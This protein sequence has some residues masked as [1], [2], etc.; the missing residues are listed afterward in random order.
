M[1][2]THEA[3]A[4]RQRR[5]DHFLKLEPLETPGS[6][7]DVD[8]RIDGADLVEVNLLGSRA[9]DFRLGLGQ[10]AEN[11]HRAVLDAGGKRRSARDDLT[12][13]AQVALGLRRA[14]LNVELQR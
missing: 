13:V 12:D 5:N 7:H 6:G 14:H 3:A 4:R 1:L 10:H 9:M 8:N 2:R 11:R